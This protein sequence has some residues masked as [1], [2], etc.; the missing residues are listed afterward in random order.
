MTVLYSPKDIRNTYERIENQ[1]RT[2]HII[3]EYALNRLDIRDLALSGLDL[4]CARRVL[5]LGCGYG[6]FTEKLMGR[7]PEDA[8]IQGM[9]IVNGDNKQAFE[10]IARSIGYSGRFM[11]AD[12]GSITGMADGSYDLVIACY[13]LYF[14]PHLIPHIARI[15]S[16][17]GVCIAITHSRRSLQEVTAFIPGCMEMIGLSPPDEVMITQLLKAFSLE[18]GQEM[19]RPHFAQV[20]KIVYPNTLVFPLDHLNDCVD[21]LDKKKHLILKD[22]SEKYAHRVDD[23]LLC[24][25]RVLTDHARVNGEIIITKDDA[26]FRCFRPYG[27]DA[28][29]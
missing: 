5:D 26:I 29:T 21:Y 7:L 25:H 9:D 22:V 24:L 14:F 3:R 27:R 11:Q 10:D 19:L 6:F 2:R 8:Y 23:M 18:N 1:R 13:S 12:A 16:P 28:I 20:E 17:G 4:G 15:L